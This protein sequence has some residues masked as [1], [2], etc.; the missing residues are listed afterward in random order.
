[1]TPQIIATGVSGF[2]GSFGLLVDPFFTH[3]GTDYEVTGITSLNGFT[4]RLD[5]FPSDDAVATW[6]VTADGN[7]YTL[8][9][10]TVVQGR[11]NNP[12]AFNWSS[13]AASWAFGETDTITI[14]AHNS[15][16]TGAPSITGSAD[17]DRTLTANTSGIED[18]NGKPTG[19]DNFTYQWV[20]V[21][22]RH[23]QRHPGRHVLKLQ[24]DDRRR[25]QDHQG[26]GQLHRQRRV[27]RGAVDQ[28]GR[29]ETGHGSPKPPCP[30][31]GRSSGAPLGR[32]HR[33]CRIRG[34][35]RDPAPPVQPGREDVHD[36]GVRH[37]QRR[38]HVYRRHG[39]RSPRSAT[40]TG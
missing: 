14:K 9:D 18:A 35:L 12:D 39:P 3:Q 10:G 6:V 2:A 23:G 34:R 4:F 21:G 28:R 26:G 29:T 24:A 22:E 1:M 5:P 30:D 15:P 32:A 38:Y 36:A 27:R 16:A 17:V 19:A 31:R 33:G 13:P 25:G 11:N 20:R 7:D 8:A 37:R 40:P